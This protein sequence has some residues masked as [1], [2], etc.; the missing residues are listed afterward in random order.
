MMMRIFLHP[1]MQRKFH[2]QWWCNQL[3][4]KQK[5][6]NRMDKRQIELV[7]CMQYATW[8]R[9]CFKVP[10][11][12]NEP[13]LISKI[14]AMPQNESSTTTDHF[15]ARRLNDLLNPTQLLQ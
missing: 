15:N 2:E 10:Y 5:T 3:F 12:V 8:D 13:L 4:D 11:I 9:E 1:L 6:T 14:G 7:Q